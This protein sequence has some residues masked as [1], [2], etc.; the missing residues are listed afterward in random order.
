[1]HV[2][3]I[4][5]VEV[6]QCTTPQAI[7]RWF[8]GTGRIEGDKIVVN[9]MK[10]THGGIFGADFDLKTVERT[11]W[12]V[13]ELELQCEAGTAEFTPSEPGFPAGTLDLVRLTILE[14]LGCS[15]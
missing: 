2:I 5:E 13:L 10:T 12:G 1:M 15:G 4:S 11:P 3:P 7:R 8:Y 6:S 14:G 9:N